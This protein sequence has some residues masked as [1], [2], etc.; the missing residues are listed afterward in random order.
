MRGRAGGA[1]QREK[2]REGA[3]TGGEKR[4]AETMSPKNGSPNTH[5]LPSFI[6]SDKLTSH[7]LLVAGYN[8]GAGGGETTVNISMILVKERFRESSV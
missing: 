1:R 3:R 4:T 2:A 6:S 8:K 7:S 5:C